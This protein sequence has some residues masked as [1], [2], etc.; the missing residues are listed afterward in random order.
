[1]TSPTSIP[2]DAAAEEGLL[3]ACL[4]DADVFH[5]CRLLLPEG[6]EEFYIHRHRWIW[7]A[8]EIL[9]NDGTAIDNITLADALEQE[10]LLEEVG[11]SAYLTR[12]ISGTPS[13]LNAT[14][15]AKIVH[16]HHIRRK[17][18]Q[19][20][21]QI[22]SLVYKGDRIENISNE[23]NHALFEALKDSGHDKYTI[24]LAD[25][26]RVVDRMID[27]RGKMDELPGIPTPWID[28][29]ETLGGGAQDSDLNLIVGRPGDGKTTALLQI[30]LHAGRYTTAVNI[31]KKKVLIFSCEMP[32]EQ[33]TLRLLSHVS[34]IN[35]QSLRAGKIPENKYNDYLLALEYLEALDIY[36]DGKP[37]ASPAYIRSKCEVIG[38]LKGLDMVCVDSLNLMRSGLDLKPHVEVDYNATELKILAREFNIPVWAAHQLNRNKEHRGKDSRPVLSDLREGGEQPADGVIF[39]HHEKN[40]EGE[41][42]GSEFVVAKQRNGPVGNVDVAFLKDKYRFENAVRIKLN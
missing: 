39:I 15:Y 33:M 21:N 25:S 29:N 12:L 8:I 14:S 22:A 19:A 31:R 41:I 2:H 20:A 5:E 23:A 30:A 10:N 17:L 3:G 26:I 42:T 38:N 32:H 18:I 13:S 4:I 9:I 1:M 37:G 40:D 28:L 11:G 16:E 34:G 35:Y 36:I 27:E 24:S 7:S 6:V